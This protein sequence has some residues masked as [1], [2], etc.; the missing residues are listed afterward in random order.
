MK[1]FM[2]ALLLFIVMPSFAQIK[3]AFLTAEGKYTAKPKRAASYVLI[4]KLDDSAYVVRLY[5]MHDTVLMQG[6]FKDELMTIPEG[7]FFFYRKDHYNMKFRTISDADKPDTNNYISQIGYFLNGSLNGTW[8]SYSSSGIVGSVVTFE[9]G[10]RNGLYQYYMDGNLLE[11]N[12]VDNKKEGNWHKH[13]M[14]D[15]LLL[16]EAEFKHDSLIDKHIY[17]ISAIE[18]NDLNTFLIKQLRKYRKKLTDNYPIIKYTINKKGRIVSPQIIKG[19]SPEINS[20]IINALVDA[21]VYYPATYNYLPVEQ[22]ITRILY[23]NPEPNAFYATGFNMYQSS[24][25]F[26]SMHVENGVFTPFTTTGYWRR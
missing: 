24:F 10:K 25:I 11:G 13:R 26:M 2:L 20:A 5:D 8:I 12:F 6:T 4:Q 15:S 14:A 22:T 17:W 16:E 7:K 1:Y 3:R 9:N 21:P 19:V 18:Q 23:L